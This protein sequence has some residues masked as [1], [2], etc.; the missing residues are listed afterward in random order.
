MERSFVQSRV[1]KQGKKVLDLTQRVPRFKGSRQ[2]QALID[3]ILYKKSDLAVWLLKHGVA[4]DAKDNK[5][6]SA[7]W[8]A[9]TGSLSAVIRELVAQGAVLPDYVLVGPVDCGDL[10]TVRFLI[11]QGANV[12][13]VAS[14]YS[15]L[16]H[17]H[18]K[19]VLLSMAMWSLNTSPQHEA[20][21]VALVRA[22]AQV[23]CLSKPTAVQGQGDVSMLGLASWRGLAKTVKA[24]I[25]MGADVNFR[26]G[27]GR[28]P[29]FGAVWAGDISIARELVRR[30]ARTDVTDRSGMTLTEALNRQEESPEMLHTRIVIDCGAKVDPKRVIREREEWQQRKTV[31]LGLIDGNSEKTN[32]R[33]RKSKRWAN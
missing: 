3:A 19:E 28:T 5:G 21:P 30:G 10:K 2:A 4:A 17:H 11:R 18:H 31:L 8:W 32:E 7:L 33:G 25:A 13:C 27:L 16:G 24:M 23:N 14:K 6:R 12:N 22:G 1:D 15:P 26:D 20:I 29:L 9:A